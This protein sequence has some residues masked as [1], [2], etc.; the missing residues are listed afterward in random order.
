MSKFSLKD[1]FR[2]LKD[3]I[4][5][6]TALAYFGLIIPS[7]GYAYFAPT[8]IKQMGYTAV[9]ANQHAVYPMVVSFWLFEHC[10]LLF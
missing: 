1:S 5:A 3:P 2:A 9:A 8:I 7:Y 10:C 6:F 4:M